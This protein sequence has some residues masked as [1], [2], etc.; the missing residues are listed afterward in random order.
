MLKP[1]IYTLFLVSFALNVGLVTKT[2]YFDFE[3]IA[4]KSYDALPVVTAYK[5][6]ISV[7]DLT[8]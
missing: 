7:E 3:I 4:Q 6:R 8:K 5:D 1:V 2:V